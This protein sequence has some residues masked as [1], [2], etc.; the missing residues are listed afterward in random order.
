[1]K[2]IKAKH[3]YTNDPRLFGCQVWEVYDNDGFIIYRQ[4]VRGTVKVCHGEKDN[5]A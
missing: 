1:M 3:Y 2:A 5:N 4:F